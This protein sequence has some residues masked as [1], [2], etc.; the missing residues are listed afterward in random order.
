MSAHPF[1]SLTV[2]VMAEAAGVAHTNPRLVFIAP[3]PELGTF[4][5]LFGNRLAVGAVPTFL[6]NVSIPDAD[7]ESAFAVGLVGQLYADN[8]LSLFVEWL[9]SEERVGQENDAA[10][11]GVEIETRGHFFKLMVT[12][13]VLLNQTQFLGGTSVDF[14]PDEWR[15][16]FNIQRLL[17]F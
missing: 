7:E 6:Y 12:N 11:F 14:T 9:V 3:S 1:A 17:P 8:A 5:A 10:T 13:Q 2:P 15:L 4:N 16:G